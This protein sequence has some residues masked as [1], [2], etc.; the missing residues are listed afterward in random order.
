LASIAFL[1]RAEELGR[2]GMLSVVEGLNVI[3][4]FIQAEA[5]TTSALRSKPIMYDASAAAPLMMG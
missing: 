4:A 3:K 1:E 2:L 5:N